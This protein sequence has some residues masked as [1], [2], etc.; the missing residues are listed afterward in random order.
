MRKMRKLL[1]CVGIIIGVGVVGFAPCYNSD[2]PDC[3]CFNN[4]ATWNPG[5]TWIQDVAL[6]TVGT[7]ESCVSNGGKPFY[8]MRMGVNS[9]STATTVA[10]ILEVLD[11]VGMNPYDREAWCSE[12]ISYWHREEG[13]PYSS[14]Y[15]N[16][17]WHLDWQLTNTEA[18]RSFYIVE[19]ILDFMFLYSG[20][21]RWINWDD[22]DYSDFQPGI[23]AP[24]P[25]SYVLIRK[26]NESSSSWEGNS[27]SMMINEMTIHRT[28]LGAV[29]RVEVTL[30][31]GNAGSPDRVRS[32]AHFDDLFALTPGGSQWLDGGRKILGFGVDL[33]SHGDP[34]YDSSRLSYKTTFIRLVTLARIPE[35]RDPFWEA[36]Y[37]PQLEKLVEYA[38]TVK[39][40]VRVSGSSEI[41]G[42]GQIPNGRDVSW[43][44]AA[45]GSSSRLQRDTEITIDLIQEHPLPLR[46]LVFHWTGAL[47][48]SLEIHYA[49]ANQ[50]VP[51]V[52]RMPDLRELKLPTP[53]RGTIAIPVSFGKESVN[54][55]TLK[56]VFPRGAFTAS[57][58]LV[59]IQFL[60][61]WGPTQDAQYNP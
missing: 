16:S 10:S 7:V 54:V 4:T 39:D 34:I 35:V 21:G 57:A 18:I 20:R 52:A 29:S 45:A 24:A 59:D 61:D 56:L 26:Y 9:S 55:R 1:V 47:P 43:T 8:Q 37:A 42:K 53:L 44:F 6:D 25:G 51:G 36:H 5:G 48:E 32:T 60:Y 41:V 19:E 12:T 49:G 38:K 22:L 27:H 15:R 11:T 31:D 40:G 3:T 58:K 50:R 28:G 23:N 30:L 46:G 14:G 13:I 33:N 2:S 17:S